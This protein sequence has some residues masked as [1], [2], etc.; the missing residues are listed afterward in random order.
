MKLFKKFSILFLIVLFIFSCEMP[1][2]YL[3]IPYSF[4]GHY[5]S[6]SPV[7]DNQNFLYMRIANGGVTVYFGKDNL[8]NIQGLDYTSIRA[9]NIESFDENSYMFQ[10]ENLKGKITFNG[11]M[12]AIVK[13][14]KNAP[15]TFSIEDSVLE[16]INSF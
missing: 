5:K 14:T 9:I 10:T 3:G 1:T 16:K 2:V 11:S 15:P 13:L 6:Q 7:L 8:D 4:D 12:N